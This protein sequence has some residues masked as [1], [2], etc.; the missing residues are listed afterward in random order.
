MY[1]MSDM[2]LVPT[3]NQLFLSFSF[4]F[5]V[6]MTDRFPCFEGKYLIVTQKTNQMS[7]HNKR[8]DFSDLLINVYVKES[9]QVLIT[10]C[11]NRNDLK[12]VR[13]K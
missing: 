6:Y 2:L 11:V 1:L 13:E 8:Y 12:D 7:S 10:L 9:Y 4:A 3:S 5:S